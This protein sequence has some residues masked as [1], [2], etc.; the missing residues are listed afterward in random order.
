[1][2]AWQV[3]LPGEDGCCILLIVFCHGVNIHL[4]EGLL[5]HSRVQKI[6]HTSRGVMVNKDMMALE[7]AVVVYQLTL[8]VQE[9]RQTDPRGVRCCVENSFPLGYQSR[10]IPMDNS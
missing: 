1:M 7:A 2:V 8:R 4:H 3:C 10:Q 9:F 5:V 6:V